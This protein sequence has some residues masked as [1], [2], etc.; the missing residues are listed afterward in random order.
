MQSLHFPLV[1]VAY[2]ESGGV[3]MAQ[4]IFIAECRG[5]IVPPMGVYRGV[6]YYTLD[7][8]QILI[9]QAK[10]AEGWNT[11]FEEPYDNYSQ[12]QASA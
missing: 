9:N 7:D 3:S 6:Y 10:A 4:S 5:H 2:T 11:D 1:S 12:G 8:L